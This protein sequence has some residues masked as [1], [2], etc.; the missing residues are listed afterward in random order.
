MSTNIAIDQSQN[1]VRSKN[2]LSNLGERR[3]EEQRYSDYD[4]QN[5]GTMLPNG[6]I[7]CSDC[8][9]SFNQRAF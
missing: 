1:E 6:F 9:R 2:L 5:N 4:Q 8:G 3:R 7:K